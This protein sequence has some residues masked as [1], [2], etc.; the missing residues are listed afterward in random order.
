MDTDLCNFSAGGLADKITGIFSGCSCGNVQS[1]YMNVAPGIAPDTN[2]TNAASST[3]S[4]NA[5]ITSANAFNTN[6][7]SSTSPDN[8]IQPVHFSSF[9]LSIGSVIY[10]PSDQD[11]S[12][13]KQALELYGQPGAVI[14][15]PEFIK[16]IR[17]YGYLEN[18]LKTAKSHNEPWSYP[19]FLSILAGC[20]SNQD[21]RMILV[22]TVNSSSLVRHCAFYISTVICSLAGE[23]HPSVKKIRST[24][25]EKTLSYISRTVSK[26]QSAEN[27]TD[28]ENTVSEDEFYHVVNTQMSSL[29]ELNNDI[30]H[31]QTLMKC[32]G[33]VLKVLEKCQ[34]CNKK[35]DLQKIIKSVAI[36]D[37]QSNVAICGAIL[38]AY[39]GHKEIGEYAQGWNVIQRHAISFVSRLLNP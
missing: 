27:T 16:V 11:W 24:A 5:S 22:E 10:D 23:S 6:A 28:I 4:A 15:H 26:T 34:E 3:S 21:D 36:G 29:Q 19:I 39:F 31:I 32:I 37:S 35:P 7:A 30:G 18:P 12:F 17:S 33:Y 38:G 20:F 25:L 1:E 9:L 14:H 8:S 2:V 13:N